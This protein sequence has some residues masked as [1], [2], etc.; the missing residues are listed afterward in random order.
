MQVLLAG[1]V[2]AHVVALLEL[3]VHLDVVIAPRAQ[4]HRHDLLAGPQ[5][6]GSKDGGRREVDAVEAVLGG[7]DDVAE[8]VACEEDV[9][10]SE[11]VGG[12]QEVLARA[13]Q[14]LPTARRDHVVADIHQ[15]AGLSA[16]LHG[17]GQVK[18]HFVAV[19]VGVVRRT[20][21]LQAAAKGVWCQTV[22]GSVPEAT[23]GRGGGG[24]DGVP[25]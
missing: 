12:R 17:L 21:A 8:L 16:R 6:D 24:G 10:L 5:L 19:K 14:G 18:V 4:Q 7:G 20:H 3:Q 1:R 25:R 2:G 9:A 13:N 23:A 15:C 11:E 22:V